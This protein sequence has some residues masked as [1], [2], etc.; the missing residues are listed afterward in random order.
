[1][2]RTAIVVTFA[3]GVTQATSCATLGRGAEEPEERAEGVSLE[4]GA[5]ILSGTALEDGS[6]SVLGT[7]R[8]KIPSMRVQQRGDACPQI[9]L[10][11]A[12][13]FAGPVNPHVYV[14]G[15]RATDTCILEQLRAMDAQRVEVYPLGF[16]TRP[17]YG[18]HAQGL[19]LIFMRS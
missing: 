14:D 13:S 4:N 9:A 7:M 17:G 10:R 16:T 3:L 18:R 1:M 15:T 6:G 19:I 8:G 12:V 11:N 5:V 2:R